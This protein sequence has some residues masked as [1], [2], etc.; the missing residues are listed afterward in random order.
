MTF[1]NC[2]VTAPDLAPIFWSFSGHM[3]PVKKVRDRPANSRCI[4]F[5]RLEGLRTG[6]IILTLWHGAC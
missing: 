2:A 6:G 1:R 3:E 5:Y 4:K